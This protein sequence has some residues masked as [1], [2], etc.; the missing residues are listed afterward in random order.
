MEAFRSCQ[1]TCGVTS[2]KDGDIKGFTLW[3]ETIEALKKI[4]KRGNL[5]FYTTRGNAFIR[6]ELR[7]KRGWARAVF[8]PE[9]DLD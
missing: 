8:K 5:V 1:R 9:Y 6:T 4:P 2:N 7:K 3:P